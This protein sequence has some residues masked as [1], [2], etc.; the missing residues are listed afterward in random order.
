MKIAMAMLYK[1]LNMHEVS[2]CRKVILML[3]INKNQ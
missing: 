2:I 1:Y 3:Q